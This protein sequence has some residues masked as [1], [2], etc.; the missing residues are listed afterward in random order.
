MT[1]KK[2]NKYSKMRKTNLRKIEETPNNFSKL[3]EIDKGYIAGIFD[4]EGCVSLQV[5]KNGKKRVIISIAN[6]NKELLV[7]IKNIFQFGSLNKSSQKVNLDVY[8]WKTS[9]RYAKAFLKEIVNF[10]HIKKDKA[11]EGINYG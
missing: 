11:M 6:S 10:L 5:R 4:G 3:S 7:W 1:F 8:Y 9:D 2:G